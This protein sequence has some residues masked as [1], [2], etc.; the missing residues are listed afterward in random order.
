[1][2]F[3]DFDA[4]YKSVC[5]GATSPVLVGFSPMDFEWMKLSCLPMTP[6]GR[7]E[8]VSEIL[9]ATS[10]RIFGATGVPVRE[11]EAGTF[12]FWLPRAKV[13]EVSI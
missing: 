8:Q 3:S 7:V 2:T 9:R 1:V 13:V 11:L 6:A 5:Y 12:R 4:A 10:F